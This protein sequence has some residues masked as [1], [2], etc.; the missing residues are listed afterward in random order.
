MKGSTILL[1]GAG[2]AAAYYINRVS[3]AVKHLR[4]TIK[5][6][7][8][9]SITLTTIKFLVTVQVYNPS[10]V[11]MQF[12]R[13]WGTVKVNGTFLSEFEVAGNSETRLKARDYTDV[14]LPFQV[15]TLNAFSV[16]SQLM[17]AIT[18]RQPFAHP[19]DIDATLAA[20]GI[21]LPIK[22]SVQLSDFGIPGVKGIGRCSSC[23]VSGI[24]D[25][26]MCALTL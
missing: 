3:N 18:S 12:N 9:D 6:V 24:V 17:V 1:I 25:C 15:S 5:G 4:A 13:L 26:S 7:K 21:E 16:I 14:I 2:A 11:A 22:Q 20:A 10:N 8:F 23:G 19:F